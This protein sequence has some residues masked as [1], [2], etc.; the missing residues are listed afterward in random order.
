MKTIKRSIL[1]A[2]T[3]LIFS[4]SQAQSW[5]SKKIKGNGDVTTITRTTSDY[6]DI[7]FLDLWTLF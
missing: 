4:F 3:L 6:S 2:L 7:K 1:L 5:G